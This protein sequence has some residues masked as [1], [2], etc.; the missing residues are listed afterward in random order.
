ME[1]KHSS[2]PHHRSYVLTYD[3]ASRLQAFRS[4]TIR[5][6]RQDD[7]RFDR[8]HEQLLMQVQQALPS[9]T[10]IE[11]LNMSELGQN[12][13]EEVGR[14]VDHATDQVVVSTCPEIAI[15][16]QLCS[17]S[18]KVEGRVLQINRLF[19]NVGNMIGYGP[20]PGYDSLDKQLG[21][22]SAKIAG[23]SVILIEDGAF[24]GGTLRYVI[25]KLTGHG[26]KV[27][28]VIVGFCFPEAQAAL[29]ETFPGNV[30]MVNQMDRLIDWIPDHDLIPFTP[31]CGRVLGHRTSDGLMPV[32]TADGASCAYPYILPFGR[33]EKWASLPTEGARDLSRF[34]LDTAIELFADIG[35]F[36]NR[37]ITVKDLMGSYPR[38]SMPISV[39]DPLD[40]LSLDTEVVRFLKQ[41][42]EKLG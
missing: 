7:Q 39:G 13:W 25:E 1:S 42:R 33:T 11:T 16:S 12:I 22:L 17:A 41:T 28:T 3:V 24:S 27:S 15:A 8:F 23:R 31:N 20:R 35:K 36:S 21:D 6:P 2:E 40:T 32:L 5:V 9:G 37:L 30:V 4:D 19:D 34:C 10:K 38:V 18:L 14:N 29:E 26:I